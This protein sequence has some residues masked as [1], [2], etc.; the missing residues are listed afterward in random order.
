MQFDP[1]WVD[2]RFGLFRTLKDPQRYNNVAAYAANYWRVLTVDEPARVITAHGG[3]PV[4]AYRFDFD[5]HARWPVN[6]SEMAGAAHAFEIPFIFGT[7]E[8]APWKYIFRA[9]QERGE[10][11][12]TMM[13][14]WGAFAYTSSPG[15]GRSGAH[16]TWQRWRNDAEQL[17]LF[18][19]ASDG[20]VRMS[21]SPLRVAEIKHRLA[22]DA[23][24]SQQEK[25]AGYRKLFLNGYQ[26]EVFYDEVEY[27]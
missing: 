18:D 2:K 1:Q 27:R 24:M 8:K 4:Y 23:S 22:V 10:L 13:D 14:Y 20:G 16:P 21:E 17:M 15:R 26:T 5:D 12:Q 9:K 19:V 25:C 3:A 7:H 6:F 11:S